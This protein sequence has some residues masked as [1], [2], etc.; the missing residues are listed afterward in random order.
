VLLLFIVDEPQRNDRAVFGGEHVDRDGVLS[1]KFR[2]LRK[3]H[4]ELN[5]AEIQH[6]RIMQIL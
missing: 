3:R 2:D 5:T 1:F 4:G 6:R